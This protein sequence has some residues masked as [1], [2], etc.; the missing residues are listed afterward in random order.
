MEL[1]KKTKILEMKMDEFL[2]IT[3]N[4]MMVFQDGVQFY[5]RGDMEALDHQIETIKHME[6]R[7][8]KLR[9]EIELQLYTETL[10]PDS[11][12]DVLAILENTDDLINNAKEN[13]MEL[14]IQTPEIASEFRQDFIDLARHGYLASDEVVKAIRAFLRNPISVR[15]YLNKVYHYEKAADN[16]TMQLKLKIFRSSMDLSGKAHLRYFIHHFDSI[17]DKAED[18]ADRL[19]IY[20]IKRSI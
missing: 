16:I 1:F 19:A 18:V 8:D 3:S 14:F 9:R 12:G 20:T 6:R 5:M 11:R 2:D 17:A 15:D 13:L 4:S 10:I 7:A